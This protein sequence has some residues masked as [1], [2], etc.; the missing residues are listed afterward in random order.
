VVI[1]FVWL[2]GDPGQALAQSV[3]DPSTEEARLAQARELYKLGAG[4][5]RAGRYREAI[6]S[7]EEAYELSDNKKILYNIANAQ[8]RLG[9]LEGAIASLRE[10]R[11]FASRSDVVSLDLRIAALEDRIADQADA[12]PAPVT[13]SPAPSPGAVARDP[14]PATPEGPLL[15][16]SRRT[17]RWSLVGTGAGLAAAFGAAA[18]YTYLDGQDDI[19]AGDEDAYR[20]NRTLNNLAV[21]LAGV[22]G[23]LVVLGFALPKDRAVMVSPTPNGAHFRLKF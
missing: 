20:T 11:P 1:M 22:S 10:Y 16:P 12:A 5:Y 14:A 23:G 8:E 15:E 3:P 13:P 21:P 18:V 19:E 7:F 4:L 2:M 9:D 17:P 6:A